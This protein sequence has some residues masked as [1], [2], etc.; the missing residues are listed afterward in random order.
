MAPTPSRTSV[1]YAS[2]V[3]G[4]GPLY[5]DVV[6]VPDGT[7]KPLTAVLHGFHGSRDDVAADTDALA[8]LGLFCVAPDMRGHGQSA[9]AHDCGALQICDIVDALHMAAQTHPAECDPQ[10][11]NAVGYSGGGGNVLSLATK[12]PELLQAGAA[13]FGISDYELWYRTAGRPDCNQ[14]MARAL[15]GSPEEA[16]ERYA[17]RSALHAVRNNPHAT[18]HLFWD[19]EEKDCPPLLNQWFLEAAERLGHINVRAHMSRAAD[20]IRWRHGYRTGV[21][22]LYAADAIFTPDFL[23]P[24]H[25]WRVPECGV[26]DACGYVVTTRF[27]AWLGDGTAGHARVHYDTSDSRPVVRPEGATVP[28]NLRLM[29]GPTLF[30][31]FLDQP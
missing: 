19:E 13:F 4:L 27:A 22:D 15:G 16:P 12:F 3:D 20:A 24:A 9:G 5:A 25:P 2:R 28:A 14:T 17:A 30:S 10:R 1:S 23:A 7:R 18:L 26:L 8:R 6:F 29:S 11:V 21:P 31:G